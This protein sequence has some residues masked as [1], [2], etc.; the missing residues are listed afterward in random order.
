MTDPV[1]PKVTICIPTIGR[2]TYIR[3]TLQSLESQTMGDYEVLIL[4]SA[5]PPEAAATFQEIAAADQRR[6][7][8]KRDRIPM[9]ANFN[10]GLSEARGEYVTFFHD[11]DVYEPNF[12]EESVRHLDENPRTGF[13]GSNYTIIDSDG[14]S[15]GVRKLIGN[16]EVQPGREFILDI[17][18]TGRNPMPLPGVVFR[19]EAFGPAGFDESL[20]MHFGDYVVLMEIAERW[21][22]MLIREP[23]MRLRLHGKNASNIP[24]T[25]SVALLKTAFNRYIHDFAARWP[26]DSEFIRRLQLASRRA[27][28]RMLLWGWISAS[29][30]TEGVNCIR[31]LRAI[32]ANLSARILQTLTFL[33]AKQS[34]RQAV[35]APVVRKL[36]RSI[37]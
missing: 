34:R 6:R 25:E 3:E 12:L 17:V 26:G 5:S 27:Y 22:V 29:T 16:T 30:E 1:R 9:F 18:K 8:V 24:M 7:V 23:L 21:D 19:R 4:D 15:E 36:G 32:G 13:S 14:K 37:S 2:L 35:L 10:V 31:E 28:R 11:D 33:G 20:S